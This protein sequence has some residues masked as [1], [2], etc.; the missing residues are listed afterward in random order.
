MPSG[1]SNDAD[2]LARSSIE[3]SEALDMFLKERQDASSAQDKAYK[4]YEAEMNYIISEANEEERKTAPDVVVDH[5]ILRHIHATGEE[6]QR[7]EAGSSL[8]TA[9]LSSDSGMVTK[10]DSSLTGGESHLLFKREPPSE[11][12]KIAIREEMFD[13]FDQSRLAESELLDSV[14]EILGKEDAK[15]SQSLDAL[16]D[17][18]TRNFGMLMNYLDEYQPRP[19]MKAWGNDPEYV[20]L[21]RKYGLKGG[22]KTNVRSTFA[23]F[24]HS[25]RIKRA[26]SPEQV[27]R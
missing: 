27:N 25:N 16:Y 17:M 1:S 19:F 3:V 9:S 23:T 14:D 24:K 10:V 18:Q 20:A 15:P 2:S 8:N 26:S 22:E 11:A 13:F 6:P 5:N 21:S 7:Y 12:E 4:L